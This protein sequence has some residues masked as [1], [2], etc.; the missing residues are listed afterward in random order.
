VAYENG[1][2]VLAQNNDHFNPARYSPSQRAAQ[3][4]LGNL[5]RMRSGNSKLRCMLIAA[6][7]ELEVG[8]AEEV[9]GAVHSALT[10][11]PGLADGRMSWNKATHL[12]SSGTAS[13]ELQRLGICDSRCRDY[14]E[15]DLEEYVDYVQNSNGKRTYQSG[16]RRGKEYTRDLRVDLAD[17]QKWS[18]AAGSEL[19]EHTIIVSRKHRVFY[20]P[21][22]ETSLPFSK[23]CLKS[24]G[25]RGVFNYRA[26]CSV[27]HIPGLLRSKRGRETE[28]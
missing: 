17:V 16:P 12:I 2:K 1:K 15:Q 20:D 3:V 11:E 24:V 8:V 26:F 9:E 27:K 23:E 6:K 28:G 5:G 25:I 13:I 18:W 10:V 22:Q 21:C 14:P 4:A 7:F 19:S